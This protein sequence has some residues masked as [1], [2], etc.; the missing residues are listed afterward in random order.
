MDD[1]TKYLFHIQPSGTIKIIRVG[2][3]WEFPLVCV[4]KIIVTCVL[5]VIE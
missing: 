4:L 5:V 1:V 2:N 3:I